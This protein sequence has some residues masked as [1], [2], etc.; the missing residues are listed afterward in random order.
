LII[1]CGCDD[2]ERAAKNRIMVRDH[3]CIEGYV[4]VESFLSGY[5]TRQPLPDW[6]P[7]GNMPTV[8]GEA[9]RVYQREVADDTE[10]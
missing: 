8:N 6:V 7:R 3:M 10:A 5:S 9:L 1:D 4:R 2:F